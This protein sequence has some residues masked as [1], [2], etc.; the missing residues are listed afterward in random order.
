MMNRENNVG[1]VKIK[2]H[3]TTA[4]SSTVKT[5]TIERSNAVDV[6]RM[7]LH[8]FNVSRIIRIHNCSAYIR[9]LKT[10]SVTEFMGGNPQ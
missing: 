2:Q 4:L 3:K 6:V 1:E 9:M 7:K 5:S 8:V 10:Q